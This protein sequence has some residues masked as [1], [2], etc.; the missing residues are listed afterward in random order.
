MPGRA[1]IATP[2]IGATLDSRTF[3][4]SSIL[5]S[6]PRTFPGTM[7]GFGHHGLAT[8]GMQGWDARN[9]LAKNRRR[10]TAR[11][12]PAIAKSGLTSHREI[13]R[14]FRLKSRSRTQPLTEAEGGRGTA[15]GRTPAPGL[16]QNQRGQ[17]DFAAH[18]MAGIAGKRT[19]LD[20]GSVCA[21]HSHLR[22]VPGCGSEHT[23]RKAGFFELWP[24]G[25]QVIGG[26]DHGK[27]H[28]QDRGQHH[29]AAPG[30]EGARS[31][32]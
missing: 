24:H 31:T 3:L 30:I 27:K 12:P 32:P 22:L 11:Q 13:C 19:G 7:A 28:Y 14:G 6:L 8:L 21:T 4:V 25:V 23:L 29:Q 9:R 5:S 2:A 1:E 17:P 20:R 26:G 10:V 15:G 16:R 18:I